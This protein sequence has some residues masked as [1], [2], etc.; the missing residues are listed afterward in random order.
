MPKDLISTKV[1]K[2]ERTKSE[3]PMEYVEPEYPYGMRLTFSDEI[4]ERFPILKDLDAEEAVAI[5]AEGIVTEIRVNDRPG[6]KTRTVEIQI[7][8][9]NLVS[10][11]SYDAAFDE[12]TK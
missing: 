10:K 7:T 8:G 11:A 6:K 1:T 5:A 12:A 3:Q 2:K 9:I 4:S